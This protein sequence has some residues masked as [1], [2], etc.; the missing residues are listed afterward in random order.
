MNEEKNCT[1]TILMGFLLM[2]CRNKYISI[3]TCEVLGMLF[4]G[5]PVILS[6]DSVQIEIYPDIYKLFYNY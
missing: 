6:Y 3:F 5:W 1:K 2:I 4:S